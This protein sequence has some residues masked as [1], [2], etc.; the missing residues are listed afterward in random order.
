M[1]IKVFTYVDAIARAGSIRKAAEEVHV[2]ASAL[3][4]QLRELEESLGVE[5]FERLPRGMRA[6]GAGEMLLAHIRQQRR[7][8]ALIRNQIEEMRGL[9]RA[10]VHVTAH[11]SATRD[12]L[13]SAI[14]RFLRDHPA[15]T[16]TVGMGSTARTMSDLLEDTTELGLLFNPQP[17]AMLVRLGDVEAPLHAVMAPD[18]PLARREKLWLS[19]CLD[20]PYALTNSGQAGSR[21]LIEA[22]AQR[23]GVELRPALQSESFEL[24]ARF[25]QDAGGLFFQI[26]AGVRAEVQRGAL[27]A[28]ALKDPPL[29]AARLVLLARRGR[30]L[31]VAASRFSQTVGGLM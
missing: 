16:F 27:V 13:S 17:H 6:T 22:Q 30:T 14:V 18:H 20:H 10:H 7:D 15:V 25:A 21:R 2:A 26:A 19:D 29:Q 3:N 4:R 11:E 12:L 9:R 1:L 24:M 31:S 28:I 5:L 23:A 8:F